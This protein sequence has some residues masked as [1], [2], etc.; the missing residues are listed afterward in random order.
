MRFANAVPADSVITQEPPTP[1]F[2]DRTLAAGITFSHLQGDM[3]LTGLNEVM[4]SGVCAF[5]YDNDGWVDLFLVNGTGQTRYYGARHWWHQPKGHIL[6]R[7]LGNG[8]FVDIT[9]NA[10]LSIQTW[11]MGCVSGDLDNDGDSDLLITNQGPNLL[12]QNNGNGSFTNITDQSGIAGE[13][14]STSASV[15]DYDGDGLL[16]I[17]IANYIDFQKGAHTYEL[18]SQFSGA[19][20]PA[21]DSSLYDSQANRLYRNL[22]N[23]KF[24]DVARAAGVENA[25]GRGLGALWFDA[26]MDNR[27]DLFIV[28]DKG[29]SPN[30]LYINQ[31][32]GHFEEPDIAKRVNT[33][34]GHMGISSGDIDNDGD[35]DLVVG[36]DNKHSHLLLVNGGTAAPVKAHIKPQVG[37]FNDLARP[38]G[39]GDE[40]S[41]GYAGW[42]PGLFDFNNDGW[43]DIFMVNGLTIPDPDSHKVSIGQAKQLWINQGKGI[44]REV[45]TQ[46]GI[47]IKDNQSARGAAFADFDNDGDIDIYV[48]HNNDLGQLLINNT[49]S[50]RWLGIKLEAHV[51]NLNAIGAKVWLHTSMGTQFRTVTSGNG[52]LSDSD[53]R[54]HFGLGD[55]ETIDSVEVQWPNGSKSTYTNIISDRYIKIIQSD[56]EVITETISAYSVADNSEQKPLLIVESKAVHMQYLNW[57]ADIE[58]IDAVLPELELALADPDPQIRISAIDVL[59]IRKHPKSFSLLTQALSDRA[60]EV[61]VKAVQTLKSYEDE[62]SIRWLL[63]AF[64]DPSADVRIA[65]ANC[66]AFFFREEEAVVHRKYLA[67]PYLVRMLEDSA[68]RVRIAAARSLADSENY[69]ALDPLINLLQNSNKEVSAEAARALGLIRERKAIPNLLA[70]LSDIS[71]SPIAHANAL[72]ALKRL[73]YDDIGQSINLLLSKSLSTNSIENTIHSISVIE[74]VFNNRAEGVVLKQ[75]ALVLLISK[76]ITNN[77]TT[78]NSA[79]DSNKKELTQK[80][81]KTLEASQS[82]LAITPLKQFTNDASPA[83]RQAAYQALLELDPNNRITYASTGLE[84]SAYEV[85]TMILNKIG[86][87]ELQHLPSSLLDDGLSH[88][89][90]KIP[91]IK[92]LGYS[93]TDKNIQ[94]LYSIATSQQES[95][96][97]RITAL[98]A[99][100]INTKKKPS[101]PEQLLLHED[102]HLQQAALLY[103]ASQ[104]RNISSQSVPPRIRDA[105]SSKHKIIRNTAVQILFARKEGWAK[106]AI[107]QFLLSRDTNISVRYKILDTLSTLKSRYSAHTILELA[108]SEHD[109]LRIV[110]LEKLTNFNITTTDDFLWKLVKNDSEKNEIRFLAARSLYPRHGKAVITTLHSTQH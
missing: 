73:N 102:T 15:V 70:F 84:D 62:T 37:E 100:T 80:L 65:V 10:G 48:A 7:N 79:R 14:W 1:N 43:L 19:D 89:A 105:L 68:P 97:A 52:F 51:G 72:I 94:Q 67:V 23:L 24:E 30:T 26:N 101:L 50:K 81:I 21:F 3:Q 12:Y 92:L 20:P 86:K 31:G 109:S 91:T 46:A 98:T 78:L 53:K 59:T 64:K 93:S 45:S 17:Y 85:R 27:P 96:R 104:H 95:I 44:F 25:G 11:G 35:L 87:R 28:N 66:F 74:A 57:L 107:R 22:G 8:R 39:I 83:V 40:Q 82:S 49:P 55:Q 71:Q 4:G 58:D 18:N 42:S 9:D 56:P 5:D 77:L 47:A 36:S 29:A 34:L 38:L 90:T 75:E 110:A 2:V 61:R 13:H 6:Y 54:L 32:D 63:R 99:L 16:D 60:A 76:W 33:A 88:S 69:R 106:R 108:R 41:V 103:W